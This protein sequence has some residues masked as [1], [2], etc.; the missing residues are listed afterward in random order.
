VTPIWLFLVCIKLCIW[1]D[2]VC[3][4]QLTLHQCTL[5][6]YP[7]ISMHNYVNV[8]Y[9]Y[10]EM[11]ILSSNS[12]CQCAS[13]CQFLYSSL[14]NHY[15]GRAGHFSFTFWYFDIGFLYRLQ[16]KL[17]KYRTSYHILY[18]HTE[19][20]TI[21]SNMWWLSYGTNNAHYINVRL[22]TVRKGHAKTFSSELIHILL[23]K[24]PKVSNVLRNS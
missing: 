8:Y 15:T 22:C 23:L 5:L 12:Q 19:L 13:Q 6:G 2:T 24:N 1:C 7:F 3:P 21:I 4:Y 14:H 9:N 17:S 20:Q 16:K 11:S 18:V 10:I